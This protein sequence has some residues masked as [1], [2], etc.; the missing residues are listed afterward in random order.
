MAL[1]SLARLDRAA[2]S[3]AGGGASPDDR[4]DG[5]SGYSRPSLAIRPSGRMTP[6]GSHARTSTRVGVA[7]LGSLLVHRADDGR[8]SRA[9]EAD[10]D[11]G[12]IEAASRSEQQSPSLRDDIETARRQAALALGHHEDD[13]DGDRL[14]R[15]DHSQSSLAGA[16]EGDTEGGGSMWLGRPAVDAAHQDDET[17]KY[18]MLQMNS[19]S[20]V[21]RTAQVVP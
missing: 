9:E 2:T 11:G 18:G 17:L 7:D 15:A 20:P 1:E 19:T 6:G 16:G 21:R 14:M 5:S 13:A 3:T 8:S 10:L 4:I 12:V